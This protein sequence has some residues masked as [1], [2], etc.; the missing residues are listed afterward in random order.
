ML[1]ASRYLKL[2]R[3]PPRSALPIAPLPSISKIPFPRLKLA[4]LQSCSA[5]FYRAFTFYLGKP[6]SRFLVSCFPDS[7]YLR[8]LRVLRGEIE[9]VSAR[10]LLQR[11]RSDGQAFKPSRRDRSPIR[12]IRGIRGALTSFLYSCRLVSIRG[13]MFLRMSAFEHARGGCALRIR[14]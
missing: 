11:T 6:I 3:L 12:Y 1:F 4:R 5:V 10:P 13:W 9:I 2:A 8:V 7:K 14:S